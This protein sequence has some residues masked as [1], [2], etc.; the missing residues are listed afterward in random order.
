M[1]FVDFFIK[2]PVF[3]SVCALLILLVG[4]ISLFSLPLDRF[5]E[6]SPTK[7]QVTSNY[8]GASAEV[9]ENAVT[10]ILERQINGVEGLRYISSTSSNSGTSSITVTFDSSRDPDLAAV[11]V[12]NQVAV[13][14][15]QLPDIVQRTGVQV[16]S[17]S[18]N[19][20]LGMGLYSDN[21][22]YDNIFLSN[23]AD[24]YLVDALKR[25]EGV[26][27]VRIFGERRYAMRLWLDPNRLASRGLTTQ[28]VVTAL[29][30]QNLQVG[31]GKIGGEPAVEGQEYQFDLR[32]ISQLKDPKEF[33]NLLLKT[34]E[35]GALVY[36]K[37][38]GRAE[39]GAEDY[40]SF[41]RFRGQEAVGIGIYQRT[42]SNALEVAKR[43]KA[44]MDRLA[45][46]FPPDLEYVVAFDTT[47]F[48]EESLSEV[49]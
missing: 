31:A 39:L 28:D 27:N 44:E 35:N 14:Q 30:E 5:P 33:D 3:S 20:L 2:R 21:N 40:G 36:F 32:A 13:V 48:I 37:D 47:Q 11:D 15:S 17:E 8:S 16:S 1:N 9:V 7:V 19:L 24:K 23:Y 46:F 42:G 26:G 12:Q 29:S 25:L 45:E 43:V 49:V 34:D 6:I 38:V 41:L 4:I 10:N 18:N 22:R